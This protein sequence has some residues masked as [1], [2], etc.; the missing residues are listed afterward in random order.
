MFERAFDVAEYESRRPFTAAGLEVTALPVVHYD[1]RRP[2]ASACRAS[3]TLAYSGDTGPCDELVE[4]A[5]DA[6]LFLCE[7]T[8][9][10]GDA[11]GAAARAPRARRGAAAAEAAGAKRL[12]L[13][14][15]PQERPG[16]LG[17]SW[18][19][20]VSSSSSRPRRFVRALGPAGAD[21]LDD[22]ER[23]RNEQRERDQAGGDEQPRRAEAR[24]RAKR[25]AGASIRNGRAVAAARAWRT[26]AA[27]AAARRPRVHQPVPLGARADG[28]QR[29]VEHHRPHVFACLRE[30]GHLEPDLVRV[31]VVELPAGV[32]DRVGNTGMSPSR[33]WAR[34]VPLR[35]FGPTSS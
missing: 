16:R 17:S 13:T 12:L 9:E 15:R 1:D 34:V 10:R 18:R 29:H 31:G 22:D 33:Q 19:T 20:T 35:R 27:A 8:L 4:L 21:P 5:P 3:A 11:D 30:D 23:R 7:A 26:R 14:H 32:V 24:R 25:L 2:T 28:T 6:D